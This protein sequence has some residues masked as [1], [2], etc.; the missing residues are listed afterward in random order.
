MFIRVKSRRS[1]SLAE[2]VINLFLC[3]IQARVFGV[4]V[5]VLGLLIGKL[6][7]QMLPLSGP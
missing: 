7:V 6:R 3:Q 2:P 1:A 4:A 5:K